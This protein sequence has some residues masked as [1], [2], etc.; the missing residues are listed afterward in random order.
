M[1]ALIISWKGAKAA[2]VEKIDKGLTQNKQ[3]TYSTIN[4]TSSGSLKGPL[5]LYKQ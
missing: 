4:G 1:R 3:V 5:I 2:W